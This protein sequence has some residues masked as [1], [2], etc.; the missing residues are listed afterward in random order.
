MRKVC[1]ICTFSIQ[2]IYFCKTALWPY[3]EINPYFGVV[4]KCSLRQLTYD[5]AC[6][7]GLKHFVID[8]LPDVLHITDFG[9]A[10][11]FKL[12]K[13]CKNAFWIDVFSAFLEL[14]KCIE[15]NSNILS[16]VRYNESI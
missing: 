4:I 9:Y 5:N 1:I 13:T 3:S 11:M 16:P 14:R 7:S 10:F 15:T 12:I 2:Y 6:N 8:T